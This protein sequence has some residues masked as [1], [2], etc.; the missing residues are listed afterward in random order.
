MYSCT[1]KVSGVDG[2]KAFIIGLSPDLSEQMQAGV[3]GAVGALGIM[4]N[5]GQREDDGSLIYN[6]EM[7]STNEITVN[8][9]TFPLPN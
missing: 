8:G 4:E 5:M 2:L 6:I 9:N 1:I 7:N 3:F